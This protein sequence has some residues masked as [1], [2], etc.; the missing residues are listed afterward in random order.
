[1]DL[2]FSEAEEQIKDAARQFLGEACPN[3]LVRQ[4]DR[5]S[6]V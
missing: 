6:V 3:Q 2:S 5:K 4:L 1:M